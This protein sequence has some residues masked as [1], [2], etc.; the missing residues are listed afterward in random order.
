VTVLPEHLQY[1]V[2]AVKSCC[3]ALGSRISPVPISYVE[4]QCR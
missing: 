4:C 2:V 3:Y 1:V